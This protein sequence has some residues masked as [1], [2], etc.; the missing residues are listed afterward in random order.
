MAYNEILVISDGVNAQTGSLSAGFDRFMQWRSPEQRD[1]KQLDVYAME[2][3]IN[4][5]MK[6]DVVLD[7]IQN[8][9][10]FETDGAK[11]FKILAAY[12][13]YYMVNKAVEAAAKTLQD[14][15]SN[16][17]GVVWHTQ[18][19][20]K[21]LS[22]VFFSGIVSRKLGNPT[23][24]VVN[25]RNDLDDQLGQT[26]AAAHDYLRQTPAQAKSRTE[27]RDLLERKGGGI[28]FSTI[29]KFA[30]EENE[31]RMPVLNTRSDIIV[32]SDEAHRSQYGLKAKFTK[33]GVKYG[34]AQYMREALPN[35]SF[36]GFT[37]T[38]IDFS[39]KS[40]RGVFGD[41]IDVYDMSAAVR[42][43]ATV[44]IY[45]ENHI[46][47]L[48]LDP[49]VQHK[50]EMVMEEAGVYNAGEQ[51]EEQKRRAEFTLSLIHISEPTRH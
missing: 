7:L 43:H 31:D 41:Y 8:F 50:Y 33:N 14:P 1:D 34:Y 45:Y 30:P 37:G 21:S 51:T 39:D 47:P 42:D 20:G 38:P 3:L 25:D 44:R 29:Q 6:R 13:Q 9:I 2:T 24:L 28:V 22:M 32:I 4:N 36:I 15:D 26:F 16:R 11:T 10:I 23:I 5:M 12:H 40:T 18:G 49:Q 27:V 17:I 35:A 48:D 46:I 19:S